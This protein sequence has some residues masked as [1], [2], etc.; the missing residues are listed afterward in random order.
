MPLRAN[1]T[2]GPVLASYLSRCGACVTALTTPGA[3]RFAAVEDFDVN[4]FR[5]HAQGRE[6]FLHVC[7]EPSRPPKVDVRD[8]WDADLIE[9]R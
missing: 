1:D 2:S 9:R 4:P 3:H 8:S 6:R 7:H 5:R